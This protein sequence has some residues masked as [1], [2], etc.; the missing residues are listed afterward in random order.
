MAQCE[1]SA[2][3]FNCNAVRQRGNRAPD[4]AIESQA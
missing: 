4:G 2:P 3:P 1:E